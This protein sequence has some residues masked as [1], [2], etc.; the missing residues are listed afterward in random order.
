M[1]TLESV[2]DPAAEGQQPWL[3]LTLT[4]TSGTPLQDFV[5]ALSGPGRIASASSFE[6]ARLVGVISN[7][8]RLAPPPGFVLAPGGRWTIVASGP[9]LS[10]RHWND[11]T[12]AAYLVHAD[13]EVQSVAA[14]PLRTSG[15]NAPLRRGTAVKPIPRDGGGAPVS[16]TPW[17]LEVHVTGHRGTVPGL[18]LVAQGATAARAART[19]ESLT[20]ALFPGEALVRPQSEGGLPVILAEGPGFAAE[21]YRIGFGAESVTVTASHETGLLYGLITLGQILR[22]AL[23]APGHFSFP[24]SGIIVDSP[25]FGFRGMHLDVARQFFAGSEVRQLLRVMAWNKLNRFHWHLS[26]DE[27][28]RIEINALPQLTAIGAWRGEGL[29]IP[30]LLG[31]GPERTGG[32]YTQ[33][34]VREIVSEALDLGIETIPEIDIPGHCYAMLAALPH[35]RD[36]AEQAGYESVQRFAENCLNPAREIVFDTLGTIFDEL[37][38]LFPHRVIHIGADE[39]PLGAWSGS[40]EALALLEQVGSKAM[41]DAH[42]TR[43]GQPTSHH[44]DAIENSPTALLQGLFLKRISE[45]LHTRGARLGGWE[46]AAHGDVIDKE[47]AYLVGWRNVEIAATLAEQGYDLVVSPGQRFYLDMS[48]ST[49][50]SEPGAS[51]AGWSG[52][53]ETYEFEPARRWSAAALSHLLGVQACIWTESMAERALFDRLVFPRLSAIAEVGWTA[54]ERKQFRRFAAAASLMPNL[55]GYWDT[56]A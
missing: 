24:Q 39:V 7:H 52:P 56:E 27:A 12:R 47:S 37:V 11:G 36:P 42:R 8:T 15:D 6:N 10:L 54:P 23:R 43:L 53:Q 4:N 44:A 38:A 29:A 30:P 3:T 41:A 35:L 19:F 33:T 51:W 21:A 49:A 45:M 22:G 1:L 20:G 28:W 5:L 40:P 25:R 48:Q 26:D 18:D 46:E 50:F 31:T 34:T 14:L 16:I 32:Y 13:G 17:P 55:Y 9:A 2:L